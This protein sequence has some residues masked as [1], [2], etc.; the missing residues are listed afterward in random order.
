VFVFVLIGRLDRVLFDENKPISNEEKIEW[1]RGIALGMCHLHKF[2]IIHRDLAARNILLTKPKPN[3]PNQHI[4]HPKI[5]VF[6]FNFNF[7]FNFNFTSLSYFE[8]F[9]IEMWSVFDIY[10]CMI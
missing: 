5:S 9:I 4:R 8:I 10:V 1:V 2:N 6:S 7:N 3:Q